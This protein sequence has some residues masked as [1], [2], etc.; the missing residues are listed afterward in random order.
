MAHMELDRRED[1]YTCG[2]W[3]S[4]SSIHLD[5]TH[6]Y[7]KRRFNRLNVKKS[8]HFCSVISSSLEGA[9]NQNI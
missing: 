7:E 5:L 1:H 6:N 2:T 8:K 4:R 3:W 9:M